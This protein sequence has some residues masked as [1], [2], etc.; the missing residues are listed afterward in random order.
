MNKILSFTTAAGLAALLA[1]CS[2]QGRTAPDGRMAQMGNAPSAMQ[3][4]RDPYQ[5]PP[6]WRNGAG[7]PVDPATGIPLPGSG[8]GSF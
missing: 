8:N 3:Q 4:Q 5:W 7:Q 2:A 6:Q 1:A